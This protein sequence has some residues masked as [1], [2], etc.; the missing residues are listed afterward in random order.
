MS[1]STLAADRVVVLVLGLLVALLGLLAGAW[2]LSV[3][4]WL[5]LEVTT[6]TS[7]STA[8]VDDLA[9]APWW[10]WA[11]GVLGVLLVLVG[12]R[13]LAAHLPDRG[14]GRLRVAGHTS[15]DK[16]E[17]DAGNVADAAADAL[18]LTEGVRSARGSV[19]HERG[20]LVA[21][22]RVTIEQGADLQV[23]ARACDTTSADLA[24]VLGR[25]DLRC[26]V[27]VHVSRRDRA[28]PRVG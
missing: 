28:L 8:P 26:L 18:G 16:L 19:R 21:T 10:P 5:P 12:L 11:L 15:A 6:P 1:R 13:W 3:R 17:A 9:A 24:R 2:Y 7:L 23:V 22:L 25:D 14:V 4:G 20:Q 27:Q